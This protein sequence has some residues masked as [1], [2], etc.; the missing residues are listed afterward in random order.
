MPVEVLLVLAAFLLLFLPGDGQIYLVGSHKRCPESQNHPRKINPEADTETGAEKVAC[1]Q[2]HQ[3]GHGQGQ[4]QLRQESQ[5]G[6]YLIP[7]H[8]APLPSLTARP[9]RIQKYMDYCN[10]VMEKTRLPK[11]PVFLT[12][13]Y[14]FLINQETSSE[15]Q[16]KDPL[17]AITNPLK[18]LSRSTFFPVLLLIIS[19]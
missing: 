10:I 8:G 19:N 18:T 3:D 6:K 5:L 4:P 1:S 2:T 9:V 13:L 15:I 12:C 7:F 17:S 16:I 14:G 11:Y